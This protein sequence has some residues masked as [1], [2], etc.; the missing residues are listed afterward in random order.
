MERERKMRRLGLAAD[1]SLKFRLL[2][3]TPF[4]ANGDRVRGVLPIVLPEKE[5]N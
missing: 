4:S 5:C 2:T 3:H 1:F